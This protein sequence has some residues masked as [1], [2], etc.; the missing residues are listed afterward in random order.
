MGGGVRTSVV[1]GACRRILE[2][3]ADDLARSTAPVQA[4]AE[5][6]APAERLMLAAAAAEAQR[7]RDLASAALGSIERAQAAAATVKGGA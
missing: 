3:A 2:V 6:L 7:I 5:V 4:G 1:F